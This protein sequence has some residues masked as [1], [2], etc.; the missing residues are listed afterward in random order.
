MSVCSWVRR[1][2]VYRQQ[3]A[4]SSSSTNGKY[5][6]LTPRAF[7]TEWCMQQ[8]HMQRNYFAE[9]DTVTGFRLTAFEKQYLSQWIDMV[10]RTPP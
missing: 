10:R 4:A 2:G 3:G 9:T 8:R 7:T 6:P 1:T 5:R